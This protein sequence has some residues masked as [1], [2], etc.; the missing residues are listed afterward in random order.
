MINYSITID[1]ITVLAIRADATLRDGPAPAS[2]PTARKACSADQSTTKRSVLEYSPSSTCR[3]S[4]KLPEWAHAK[5]AST[6]PKPPP[7]RSMPYNT[8][9]PKKCPK[10]GLLDNQ[11]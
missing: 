4:V 2:T 9:L 6:V 11:F 3:R 8:H 1:A 5:L 7:Y 10:A